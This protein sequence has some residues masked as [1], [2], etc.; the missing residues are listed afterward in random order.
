MVTPGSLPSAPG[1]ALPGTPTPTGTNFLFW[2][3][4]QG[5]GVPCALGGLGHWVR[6]VPAGLTRS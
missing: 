6:A 5:I 1:Q 4:H 3:V 2:V